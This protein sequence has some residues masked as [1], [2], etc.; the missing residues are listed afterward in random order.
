MNQAKID[1]GQGPVWALATAEPAEPWTTSPPRKPNCATVTSYRS[2][3]E[4]PVSVKAGELQTSAR[5]SW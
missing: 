5:R 3:H 2:R 1:R 4:N